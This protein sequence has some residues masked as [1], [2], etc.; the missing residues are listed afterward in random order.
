MAKGENGIIGIF[1]VSNTFTFFL[2]F[3]KHVFNFECTDFVILAS[4]GAGF[5][6]SAMNGTILVEVYCLK[7]H[8]KFGRPKPCT[9]DQKIFL[10]ISQH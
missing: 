2:Y 4:G 1:K 3:P 5:D 10:K 9:L 7:Q 8:T 6:C